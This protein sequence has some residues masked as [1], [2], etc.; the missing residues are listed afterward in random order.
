MNTSH[1]GKE[2][3][4]VLLKVTDVEGATKT[5]TRLLS[6]SIVFEGVKSK[7]AFFVGDEITLRYREEM[8]PRN[9]EAEVT[10]A[11]ESFADLLLLLEKPASEI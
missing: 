1:F 2:A 5:R 8:G 6:K 3:Y 10:V 11:H 7:T 9:F 4:D